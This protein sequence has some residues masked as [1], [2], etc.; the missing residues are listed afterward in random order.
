M[1]TRDKPL[2]FSGSQH[3]ISEDTFTVNF[4]LYETVRLLLEM[5]YT[6]QIENYKATIE[7]GLN[8]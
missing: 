7:K 5:T 3:D 6:I 8:N 2:L 4:L 1:K